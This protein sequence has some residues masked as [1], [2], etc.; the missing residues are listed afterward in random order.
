MQILWK[1]SSTEQPV[2]DLSL[3]CKKSKHQFCAETH[4][5]EFHMHQLALEVVSVDF[6]CQGQQLS[7]SL[8]NNSVGK[9]PSL[10]TVESGLLEFEYF[11]KVSSFKYMIPWSVSWY[12]YLPTKCIYRFL[13]LTRY[14]TIK[15]M[16]FTS[17]ADLPTHISF[18]FSFWKISLAHTLLSNA[19][20]TVCI[21]T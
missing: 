2:S 14:T 12:V 5:G 19:P 15:R 21:G 17:K 16:F 13:R 8:E 3:L 18:P 1:S 10:N 11:S 4:S 6:E 7:A 9:Q 20:Y